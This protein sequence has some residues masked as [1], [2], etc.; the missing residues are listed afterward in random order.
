MKILVIS[1]LR[2]GDLFQHLHLIQ[3]LRAQY[4]GAQIDFL[5]NDSI[6][7]PESLKSE[8]NFILFP[9]KKLQQGLG[10]FQEHSLKS[11]FMLDTFI[12]SVKD[13]MYSRVVDLTHTRLSH[14]LFR[15]LQ[16]RHSWGINS[17]AHHYLNET[18]ELPLFKKN[19]VQ[20]LGAWQNL[21]V[22]CP[23]LSQSK[24]VVPKSV[25]LQVCTSDPKKDWPIQNWKVL[26]KKLTDVGIPWQIICAPFEKE[27][28]LGYF[29]PVQIWACSFD[30][31]QKAFLSDE[32]LLVSGDTSMLHWAAYYST[33]SLG[34][35][36]GS[37]N[38]F[39]TFPLAEGSRLLTAKAPCWPCRH[40]QDCSQNS[41][42]CH[43][44]I[45]VE[46]VFGQ[47]CD[48]LQVNRTDH[49]SHLSAAA[50][51]WQ[52]HRKSAGPISLRLLRGGEIERDIQVLQNV[53]EPIAYSQDL[54]NMD[55]RLA[56]EMIPARFRRTFAEVLQALPD[57]S[58]ISPTE[59][60][61]IE[62]LS[63]SPH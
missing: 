49:Q 29:Q 23:E 13:S 39:E 34:L 12:Q 16:V 48:M 1:L 22:R 52:V 54:R 7:I 27:Q 17:T 38:V 30:E 8:F 15:S 18:L 43:E 53:L 24:S 58:G 31:A 10:N 41:F 35:F 2:V 63:L 32:H 28:V 42:L 37:A 20:M 3:D 14:S 40:S 61:K 5:V 45:S 33:Q 36:V 47:V 50:S 21:K 57:R 4:P 6:P 46:D 59:L 55:L 44:E 19:L 51:L 25:L 62:E 9:R 56:F 60:H 11:F 26:S